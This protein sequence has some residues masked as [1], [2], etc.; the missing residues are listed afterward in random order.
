MTTI[1]K[2][3]PRM[4]KVLRAMQYLAICVIR[5]NKKKRSFKKKKRNYAKE[6]EYDTN[7]RRQNEKLNSNLMVTETMS[8][9]RSTGTDLYF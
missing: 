1:S 7:K 6:I 2:G 3:R 5:S 9:G 4:I 8:H